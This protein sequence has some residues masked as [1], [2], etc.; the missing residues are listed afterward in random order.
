MDLKLFEIRRRYLPTDEEL[1][2]EPLCIAGALSGSRT[3]ASW[4]STRETVDFYDV[5]GIIENLLELLHFR[6]V[7]WVAD[8]PEPYYH[9][10]KSC[11]I[12]AGRER[13]GTLGEIH[14]TV[15]ANFSIEKPVYAF[16]LDFEKLVTLS[17][18]KRSIGAPSRFPDSTRDIAMLAADDLPAE[19]I[20][21]CVNG[22]KA[23]EIEQVEIFDLYRGAGIQEGFK[24]IAIRIRYRSYERTLTDDEIGT[25]HTKVLAALVNKLNVSIR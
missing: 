18:Q 20:V 25:I 10:G 14:P 13:I 6:N 9:P 24:S 3:D 21:S 1:P 5:K 23:R 2:H 17:N 15:Q 22:V 7:T 12:M 16:E 11:S 8:A 19:Q 4:S